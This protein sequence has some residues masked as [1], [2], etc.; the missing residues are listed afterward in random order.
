MPDTLREFKAVIWTKDPDQ[1]GRQVTVWAVD[2][3]DAKRQL[4]E[5]YGP[6]QVFDLHAAEDA[7]RPR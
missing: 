7:N 4:D 6:D 1:T 5:K 3:Q 2:L